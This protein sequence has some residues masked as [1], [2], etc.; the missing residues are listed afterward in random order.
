[1]ARQD[2][3]RHQR[4]AARLEAKKKDNEEPALEAPTENGKVGTPASESENPGPVPGTIPVAWEA[5]LEPEPLAGNGQAQ[6]T[7]SFGSNVFP[8]PNPVPLAAQHS[9]WGYQAQPHNMLPSPLALPPLPPQDHNPSSVA[10]MAAKLDKDMID[11]MVR[12]FR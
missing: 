5:M 10:A 7:P 11:L 1:M 12:T 2:K 4:E 3:E 6:M 8:G 9:D